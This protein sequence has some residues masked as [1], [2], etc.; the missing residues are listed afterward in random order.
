MKHVQLRG[1]IKQVSNN[2]CLVYINVF[3]KMLKSLPKNCK[4]QQQTLCLHLPSNEQK[5]R[6]W[7]RKVLLQLPIQQ[8]PTRCFILNA[9]SCSFPSSI[10]KKV[11]FILFFL[12][13]TP[14]N[15]L[16]KLI[17]RT[18]KNYTV[19]S[20]TV[21]AGTEGTLVSPFDLKGVLCLNGLMFD[22][23]CF[24]STR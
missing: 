11:F 18:H 23:F 2:V 1:E 6:R 12:Q 19:M 7:C 17:T 20:Y 22:C 8:P 5:I 4:Q 3:S 10:Q 15:G 13:P 9:A 16:L 24:T 14:S 21:H